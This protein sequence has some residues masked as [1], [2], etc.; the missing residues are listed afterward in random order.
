MRT[1]LDFE[2]PIADLFEQLEKAEAIAEM[3]EINVK[4]TIKEIKTKI[5]EKTKEIYN[6]LT[7]WQRVQVSRHPN[8][9]YTLSYINAITE[10]F[11]ELH[12][13]R[14]VKDDKAMVGGIWKYRWTN[15]YVHWSAERCKYETEA[16]QKFWNG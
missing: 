1:F 10:D 13:D 16:I 6:D 14:N 3:G 7:P 5:K 8:R 15:D 9:P 4:A 11:I 2:Q 12:G